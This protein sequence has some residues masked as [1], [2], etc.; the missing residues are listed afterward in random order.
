[1]EPSN[2]DEHPAQIATRI[3]HAYG[4]PTKVFLP[5]YF[6]TYN[7]PVH[8][9]MRYLWYQAIKG[10]TFFPKDIKDLTGYDSAICTK[11]MADYRLIKHLF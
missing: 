7:N 5:S 3:A 10:R 1:M 6:K 4:Q 8:K 9:K 2:I 11:I